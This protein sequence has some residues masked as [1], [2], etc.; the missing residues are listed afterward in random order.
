TGRTHQVRVHFASIGHP[1]L[2]DRAYGKKIEIETKEREKLAFP[3]QM[4][5]AESLGFIHPGTGECLEFH[6]PMPEDME[7]SIKQLRG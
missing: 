3:R 2:G 6:S 5:H 4:L 1:V 7:E